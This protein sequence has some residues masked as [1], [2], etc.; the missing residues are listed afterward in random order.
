MIAARPRRRGQLAAAGATMLIALAI[1]WLAGFCWFVHGAI[2]A[3]AE[4]RQ[5]DGIVVLTGGADRIATG[6]HLLQQG[7]AR[8]LLISGVGHGAD[9][10]AL[11]RNTGIDPAPIAARVTLGHDATSTTGNADETAAWVAAQHLHSLIVVTASYHMLRAMTELQRRLPGIRLSPYAVLP[12]ALRGTGGIA[13]NLAA[14][15]LLAQ[16]YTKFIAAE[17]GL[18]RLGAEAGRGPG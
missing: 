6:I 7:R 5:A 1:L 8:V 4:T 2:Q 10:A 18:A 15:R 14:M 13:T 17:L 11:L 12:P 3:D 16:E 9:L